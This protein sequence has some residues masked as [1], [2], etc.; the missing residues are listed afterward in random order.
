MDVVDKQRDQSQGWYGIA[1]NKMKVL[2]YV[3]TSFVDSLQ[4]SNTTLWKTLVEDI[5]PMFASP[6]DVMTLE[7][8]MADDFAGATAAKSPVASQVHDF[9]LSLYQ[10]EFDASFKT[11]PAEQSIKDALATCDDDSHS[12]KPLRDALVAVQRCAATM[13]VVPGFAQKK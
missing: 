9:L 1:L 7:K 4:E 2:R 5:L 8:R 3:R 10:G 6:V 13:A 11:I 12:L